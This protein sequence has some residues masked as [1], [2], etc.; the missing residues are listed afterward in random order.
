[1][2]IVKI[3]SQNKFNKVSNWVLHWD[4][5]VILTKGFGAK[6]AVKAL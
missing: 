1:M 5:A 2:F 3:S 6:E 4:L